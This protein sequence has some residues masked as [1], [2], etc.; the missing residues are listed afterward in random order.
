MTWLWHVEAFLADES[1]SR[2]RVLALVI[3]SDRHPDPPHHKMQM[4]KTFFLEQLTA[5]WLG[6]GEYRDLIYVTDYN[7]EVSYR[8]QG[9]R[10]ALERWTQSTHVLSSNKYVKVV[11][12]G[13]TPVNR[14]VHGLSATNPRASRPFGAQVVVVDVKKGTLELVQLMLGPMAAMGTRVVII[15]EADWL[16]PMQTLMPPGWVLTTIMYQTLDDDT[17]TE[18]AE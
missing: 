7:C 16:A 11:G 10:S 12:T 18:M 3:P 15:S 9:I 6:T 5:R 1:A 13:A 4:G 14:M 8:M 2:P 17:E